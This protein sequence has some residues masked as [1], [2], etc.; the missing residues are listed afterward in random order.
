[1]STDKP[2]LVVWSEERGYYAKELTY[3]S[4][5]G[6]PKIELS[7]ADSWKQTGVS[8]VNHYFQTKFQ[9]L[10][11]LYHKYVQEFGWNDLIYRHAEYSFIPIVGHTYHLYERDNGQMFLSIIEPTAWQMRWVGSFQLDSSGKW[12]KV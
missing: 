12:I 7:N 9:E 6:A 10:K 4:N 8:N 11:E 3:G 1:M 5:I 2:D